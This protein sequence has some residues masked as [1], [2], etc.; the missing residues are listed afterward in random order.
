MILYLR[1]T[2]YNFTQDAKSVVRITVH[3]N[4]MKKLHRSNKF[5]EFTDFVYPKEDKLWEI[6]TWNST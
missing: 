6:F 1:L 3:R 5:K 4:D 2:D